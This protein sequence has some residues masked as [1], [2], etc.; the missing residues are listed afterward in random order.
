M[1][2]SAGEM[3]KEE[4]KIC[5]LKALILVYPLWA[6]KGFKLNKPIALISETEK[7]QLILW[8]KL[9]LFPQEQ[10]LVPLTVKPK[11]LEQNWANAE[12]GVFYSC[13]ARGRYTSQNLERL[14]EKSQ[15]VGAEIENQKLILI[16]SVGCLQKEVEVEGSLYFSDLVDVQNREIDIRAFVQYLRQNENRVMSIVKE[17]LENV[18]ENFAIL[19]VAKTILE[20]FLVREIS[21]EEIPKFLKS[22]SF[23]QEKVYEEWEDTENPEIY[24]IA[25][26]RAIGECVDQLP[27][28]LPRERIEAQEVEWIDEAIFFDNEAYYLPEPF[29]R[30][31]CERCISSASATY[32]KSKLVEAGVL[33]FEG[34]ARNYFTVK[35]EVV[36]VYGGIIKVRRMKL[37]RKKLDQYGEFTLQE[38]S[39]MR[40]EET[41]ESEDWEVCETWE[42]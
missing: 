18:Q 28:V 25:L 40:E 34:K 6:E 39:L 24:V 22:T 41:Y 33:V 38:L 36:T 4:W 2:R 12:Y 35:I 13:Y 1:K 30:F 32:I 31:I 27:P 20:N 15:M 21:T 9:C 17:E 5:L 3:S 19:D 26:N 7:D 8:K 16:F 42:A 14:L 29:F 37:L 23:H 10:K 11:E